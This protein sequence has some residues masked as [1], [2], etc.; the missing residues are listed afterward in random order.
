MTYRESGRWLRPFLGAAT[1]ALIAIASLGVAPAV[2]AGNGHHAQAMAALHDL[3]AAVAELNRASNLTVSDEAPYM[4]AAQRAL[5]A[6]VGKD[7][8]D[9]KADAGNPGDAQ[10]ALGHLNALL[11]EAGDAP[12]KSGVAGALVNASVAQ[13]RLLDTLEVRELGNFQVAMT[14]ALEALD[15][16]LGRD[17]TTGALGGLQ[18]ALATTAL[19][20]PYGAKTVSGCAVPADAPAYG[21]TKGYL[22][23]VALPAE[24]GD[25]ALPQSLGVSGVTVGNGMVVLHTAAAGMRKALC[26]QHA[27]AKTIPAGVRTA[28]AAPAPSAKKTAESV[29]SGQGPPKL[30]TAKQAKAGEQI[31]KHICS[32]CH[33]PDLQGKSGPA[34]AGSAFLKK[35]AALEWTVGNLRTIVVNTMPRNNPGSLTKK[36]YAD[37][38]SYLLADNCYP[39]G[40]TTF[41]TKRSAKLEHTALKAPSGVK[42][43]NAKLGICPLLMTQ[44]KG[45]QITG[46]K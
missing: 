30:Y 39:A 7:G 46:M 10:G 3:Q 20:V 27:Q 43:Q 32:V 45:A 25:T 23:Y 33:G 4:A 29:K 42:P 24:G 17:S 19:G 41:P 38:L 2:A 12:W 36:Q 15:V 13:S 35:A 28:S 6:V 11:H 37:V 44:M 31:A 14:G 9:F 18:G 16:A 34:I 1:G 8:S 40:Q 21:V 5:N 22:L 26:P